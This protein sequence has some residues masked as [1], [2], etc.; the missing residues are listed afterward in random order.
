MDGD[1]CKV[2]TEGP[3]PRGW[4]GHDNGTKGMVAMRGGAAVRQSGE[5][6]GGDGGDD[7]EERR[8]GGNVGRPHAKN[9]S[10]SPFF[11]KNFKFVTDISVLN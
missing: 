6:H 3:W 4:A 7:S 8:S 11:K 1:G 9:K 5:W 10:R 2:R